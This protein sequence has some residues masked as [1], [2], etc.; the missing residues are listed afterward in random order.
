ME[1]HNYNMVNEKS[2]EKNEGAEKISRVFEAV[3]AE[4]S[5]PSPPGDRQDGETG[6]NVRG[7]IKKHERAS[8]ERIPQARLGLGMHAG[9]CGDLPRGG[10]QRR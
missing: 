8:G 6:G 3:L 7:H 5:G 4:D 1:Q 9:G 10:M 2:K